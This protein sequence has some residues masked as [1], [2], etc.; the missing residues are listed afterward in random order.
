MYAYK[1]TEVI[2]VCVMEFVWIFVHTQRAVTKTDVPC[3]M[4]VCIALVAWSIS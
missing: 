1:A 4:A 3:R 2:D